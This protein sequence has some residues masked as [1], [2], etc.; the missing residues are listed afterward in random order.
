MEM[1]WPG[2][3]DADAVALRGM[4]RDSMFLKARID[5]DRLVHGFDIVV[6]NVSAGGLLA[7]TTMDL[8]LGDV[9]KVELRRVGSVPGRIVWV[10]AGRFGVAFDVTI[11]PQLVRQPIVVKKNATNTARSSSAFVPRKRLIS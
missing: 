5:V 1:E 7:D 6:R 11:D 3:T 8:E 2:E 4:R 9:V 10:Q